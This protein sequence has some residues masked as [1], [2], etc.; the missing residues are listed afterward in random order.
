MR[1]RGAQTART[2]M[3]RMGAEDP[4][5]RRGGDLLIRPVRPADRERV[6][7]LTR[8]IWDGHDYVPRVFD[9]WVSDAAAAFQAIELDGV[10]VGLQRLRPYASGLIWYE[11]LRVATTHRRQGLARAMLQPA[12]TEPR[13]QKSRE[14]RLATG[15]PA[16]A[17]L[18]EEFGFERLQD[19]RWWRGGRVEGG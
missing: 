12:I 3:G 4:S 6:M 8:D 2:Q 13:E 7:E 15:T 9:E 14:M 5:A 18:F 1:K 17:K 16:A 11:G 19:D 10:V